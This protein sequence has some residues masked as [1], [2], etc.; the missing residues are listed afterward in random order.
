M[1]LHSCAYIWSKLKGDFDCCFVTCIWL[2]C[3]M[4]VT[5]FDCPSIFI[6]HCECNYLWASDFVCVTTDTSVL[7]QHPC[8]DWWR[9]KWLL[10][11]FLRGITRNAHFVYMY[12]K[13]E[14][15]AFLRHEC[16]DC[17]GLH[18]NESECYC[19]QVYWISSYFRGNV[20]LK[21]TA[22]LEECLSIWVVG[23]FCMAF[24]APS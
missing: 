11:V 4:L 8:S 24:N 20:Q 17:L 3:L 15:N 13:L 18:M 19:R 16:R 12:T 7:K 9:N 1:D 6:M 2:R 23:W 21:H 10:L 22:N 14:E 5:S